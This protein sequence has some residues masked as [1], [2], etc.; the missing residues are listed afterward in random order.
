MTP[1][2]SVVDAE[3]FE[4]NNQLNENALKDLEV[5]DIVIINKVDLI[6]D[7]KLAD[8]AGAIKLANPKARILQATHGKVDFRLLL[9]VKEHVSTQLNLK[10]GHSHD[11]NHSHDHDH[12]HD[13]FQTVSLSTDKPLDPYK[14]E[15][16]ADDLPADIFRAKGIIFFGMKGVGQKFIFQ[17]V[18]RRS[19]L[20]LG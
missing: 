9:D 18:G 15:A 20:Q 1:L 7:K 10:A 19:S 6:N 13:K 4:K 12:L 17:S 16:W 11:H 8:I 2:T 14:F 5:A 3:N